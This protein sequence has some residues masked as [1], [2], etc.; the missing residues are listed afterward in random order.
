M[1]AVADEQRGL[2]TRRQCLEAGLTRKAIESRL[3]GR[4]VGVHPGVY[5][6]R[7]GRDDWWTLALAAHLA[8][9]PQAAWA[10]HT[11]AYRWGL[12]S[13][14]PRRVELMVPQGHLVAAPPGCVVSRSRHLD[15]RVDPLRWPWL[16]TVEETILDLAERGTLD[17]TLSVLGRAFQRRRTDEDALLR[18]LAVRQRHPRRALLGLVLGDV[19]GGAESAMEVRYLH[20]VERAHALPSGE[21][22]II[23]DPSGRQRHDVGYR[24]Q[25][26]L[27][28]LDGRLGH[29]DR[30]DRVHDGVRDRRSASRGWLTVRAFWTDVAG[31]PCHLALD[32][33]AVLHSRDWTGVVRPC[34][35][36]DCAVRRSAHQGGGASPL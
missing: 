27:V 31:Q 7:P 34:R 3:R 36:R 12:V 33:G 25:R 6:T 19:A 16:T 13:S 17:E 5:Q 22:Q 29:E 35:R 11:A 28:E 15:E 24:A 32:V 1:D 26:V 30:G 9:G 10:R 8:C 23:I 4:W 20:D 14:P 21:R 2:L 18:R